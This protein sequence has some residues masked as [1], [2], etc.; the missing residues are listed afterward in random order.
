[1]FK[2]TMTPFSTHQLSHLQHTSL[3]SKDTIVDRVDVMRRSERTRYR[4]SDYLRTQCLEVN[5]IQ[6]SNETPSNT[7]ASKVATVDESCRQQICEWSYRVVDYFEI[8]REVVAVAISYLDRFLCM[9]R[10]DRRIFKLTATASLLI[11]I[12]LNQ[13]QKIDMAGILA[14]LSRREF[15]RDHI[16]AMEKEILET[17]SYHLHP[18]TPTSF[19]GHFLRLLPPSTDPEVARSLSALACFF[20]E[21][22]VCDYCFTMD[23]SSTIALGSILNA[24]ETLSVSEL[25]LDSRAYFFKEL[26]SIIN[27]DC[28]S[29]EVN[30]VRKRLWDVYEQSEEFKVQDEMAVSFHNETRESKPIFMDTSSVLSPKCVSDIHSRY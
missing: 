23:R 19:V 11:A 4:C 20:N 17:L 8:D 2:M 24:M 7:T 18:P 12:K 14:D 1:M 15:S 13:P 26:S 16:I 29:S 9:R 6:S 22:A 25:S 5:N 27:L 10:C 21:L 3:L 28:S 30:D